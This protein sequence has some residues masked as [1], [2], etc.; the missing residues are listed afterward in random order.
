MQHNAR[1]TPG[2]WQSVA[3]DGSASF[4]GSVMSE[5]AALSPGL[6]FDG[7]LPIGSWGEIMFRE[8]CAV[9]T[10]VLSGVD[11]EVILHSF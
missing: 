5:I 1:E 10:S 6:M 3:S 2:K 7:C 8:I 9:T 11:K 4:T